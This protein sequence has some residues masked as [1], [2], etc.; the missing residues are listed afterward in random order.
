MTERVASLRPTA[1]NC[2]LAEVRQLQ[3]EGRSLVSLMRGQPDT[4]TPPHIVEA[5]QRALREG[6]TGYPDNQGEPI[7]RQAVAEKLQRDNGLTYDPAREILITNG[8]TCGLCTALGALIQPGDDVLLPDPI[9]DAYASPVALWGGRPVFVPA[10]I[11]DGRFVMERAALEAVHTT[12]A[13]VLLLNT[14]WNPTGTVL[15]VAELASTMEFAAARNLFVISDEIYENLVYDGR[16]HIPP[17]A[18]S[19]Q[20]RLR[21]LVVNSL[22]KTYAMTGWR[23]GYC[24]G[25]AELIQTMLLVLQ[26][27][28]RGPATFV[29]HAAAHALRS[30]QECVQRMAAEYQGRRDL[31]LQRLSGI[32]GIV[33]LVP[34][35]GLFVMV[36]IRGLGVPSDEARRFLLREAG[37]VVIHGAAYGP[38]GEGTL[39]VSFAAGGNVLEQGLDRLRHGL[40][41]LAENSS[42]K[43]GV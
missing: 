33:P 41:R 6:H 35:G 22:S 10:M 29:Q 16:R 18:V 5:V 2:V 32:P 7:L 31:V 14:P 26:Q 43:A 37:V 20:A 34:E 17:A 42:R 19:D 1:V 30:S 39:R 25:P 3:A 40:E 13:R 15:T 8:A 28:S 23:V 9:Y 12:N 21:T 38:G 27:F 4:P 24:A 36:D 11:R